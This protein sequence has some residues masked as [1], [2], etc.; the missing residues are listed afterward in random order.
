MNKPSWNE[1]FASLA[2]SVASRVTC[3][4]RQVGAVIVKDKQILTTGYNGTPAGEEHCVVCERKR[5]NI[6]PGERYEI[7]K[8][9]HAEANAIIQAAKHGVAIDGADLYVTDTPCFMC[10]RM[11]VNAGI[12][13]VYVK[14][15]LWDQTEKRLESPRAAWLVWGGWKGNHDRRI[16]GAKCL[17]CGYIHPT[18]YNSLENLSKYCPSCG[19]QMLTKEES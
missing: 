19:D 12:K 18:V 16:E 17:K 8:S 5:L 7:C 3:L 9:V 11:I 13:N 10:R 6:K 14:G 2:T 15:I 1:Y 4:R